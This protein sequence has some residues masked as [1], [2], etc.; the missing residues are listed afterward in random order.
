MVL[1]PIFVRKSV[2]RCCC[3]AT[4][5]PAGVSSS[6]A[7]RNVIK[8][9]PSASCPCAL[10]IIISR[11][12]SAKNWRSIR[13]P[14]RPIAIS[15]AL[16]SSASVSSDC[17]SSVWARWRRIISAVTPSNS[18]NC[19][20]KRLQ[21]L[22]CLGCS[23]YPLRSSCGSLRISACVISPMTFCC[24][25][26]FMRASAGMIT[27]SHFF[28]GTCTIS[29]ALI[30]PPVP[31]AVHTAVLICPPSSGCF[32]SGFAPRSIMEKTGTT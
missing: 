27:P 26:S 12:K 24:C 23:K 15:S 32:N 16:R 18:H 30:A 4:A 25:T 21:S 11:S 1:G 28:S 10:S 9:A 20:L 3:A 22:Y 13:S 31:H 2:I 8:R 6:S 5:L 19:S 17:M 14:V 29:G 7:S